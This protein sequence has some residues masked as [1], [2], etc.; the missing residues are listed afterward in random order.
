MMTLNE[1]FNFDR[2]TPPDVRASFRTPPARVLLKQGAKLYRFVTMGHNET[3]AGF[4]TPHDVYAKLEGWS[5]QLGM[6]VQYLARNLLAVT[7]EWNPK[8]NGLSIVELK[9]DAYGLRGPAKYQRLEKA[10]PKVLLI[11]NVDQVWVP[12]LTPAL[13]FQQFRTL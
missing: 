5:R 3:I 6:P 13:V 8:M 2:D 11:G 7:V 12:S 10:N 9:C 1:G 4:W